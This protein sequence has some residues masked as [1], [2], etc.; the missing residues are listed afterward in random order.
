[1]QQNFNFPFFSHK[2]YYNHAFSYWSIVK[3][4]LNNWI[5]STLLEYSIIDI[6]PTSIECSNTTIGRFTNYFMC[7]EFNFF[8]FFSVFSFVYLKT[9]FLEQKPARVAEHN[10]YFHKWRNIVPFI[11]KKNKI[12]LYYPCIWKISW[13]VIF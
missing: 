5:S 6:W 13:F 1:M 8:H 2:L 4:F 7:L 10:L 11:R 9:T 3:V 12:L